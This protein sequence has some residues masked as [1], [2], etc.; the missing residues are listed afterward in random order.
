MLLIYWRKRGNEDS[1]FSGFFPCETKIQKPADDKKK[2]DHHVPCLS[3]VLQS[4]MLFVI[5][6]HL[7]TGYSGNSKFIVPR[8]TSYCSLLC[9][10][11]Q[12]MSRRTMNLLFAAQGDSWCLWNIKLAITFIPVNTCIIFLTTFLKFV[13]L[14]INGGC[15]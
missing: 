2:H 4:L 3:M 14:S 12:L 6:K 9:L 7:F 1:K 8:D 13:L 15:R 11:Q 5:I 10:E